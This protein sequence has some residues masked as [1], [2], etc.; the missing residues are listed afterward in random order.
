MI[1]L[2]LG[3]IGLLQQAAFQ[4][5]TT[6][7][8]GDTVGYWQQRVSYTIV[9]TLDE[10]KANLHARGTLVYVNNSPDTLREI[11]VH[12]YLNAF[13]P[14]S[15]WSAVD[16]H[17]N[18]VRFQNLRD[19]DFGYERFTSPPV[20]NG[21][22]VFVDYPGSPDSTVAHFKLAAGLAPHDS[23]R[24]TFEWDA[25][26]STVPRRQGRSGRTYDFAQ[27][28]PKVAVYD[29]GGW[30]P[31][32]LVPAGELYGEYGT[33]DVTMVVRDD[34]VLASSGVPVSGDPGWARVSRNGAP[35]LGSNAYQTVPPAPPVT[36]PDG[37]RAVRFFAENVHHFAWSASPDYRYEG[38]VYVRS[39]PAR[40]HFQTWDT[41]GVH[42]LFKPGDDTTWAGGR[43]VDRTIYALQWLESIWGP[44]AYPQLSNVHR[45]DPGGTEFPM[46]IMDGSASQGLILHEAGH[47]FTYGILGNNEWRSGWMDE[48][49]TSYQTDWAQKL[50][51]QEL[52][53]HAPVPPRLP[54][55]HRANAVVIPPA[56]SAYLAQVRLELLGRAQPIGTSGAEFSEFGIYNDM[57]YDRAELMYGHLRDVMGDTAFRAF[58]H[59]YYNRWAL[60]HVDERAMRM[61]GERTYGHGLTWF[62][63]QWVRG[64]G[65]MDYSLGSVNIRT[66]GARFETTAR[67]TRRGELRHPMP[68]GVQTASGWTF[69][70]ADP[71]VDDQTVSIVTTERP[72]LVELDPNHLT[73]DWDRRNNI[74]SAFLIS[75]R[76]PRVMYNWPYLDQNDR[77]HTIVALSP[78]AWYSEPQGPVFGIR[79][80]TNYLSMVD[81]HDGGIGFS[82]R[83]PRGPTGRQPN[84]L[85]RAQLWA[86]AEN[87]YLPGFDR[88]LMGY[89]GAFNFLDGMLDVS[90]FKKWDLSPFI[91]TP[92]PAINAKL[93][94][95][96]AL[97]TDSLLLPEQW[98]NS[99]LVEAGATG[100][101][102]TAI[103]ADSESTTLRGALA[104]GAT[105]SNRI[106]G[107]ENQ[108]AYLRAEGSIAVVRSI[109][110]TASQVHVRIYG[111]VAHNAPRQRAIFA[112]SEDPLETFN[113]D[114]FRPR[115]ALLK[116]TGINYLPLGGAGF[117]GF[118]YNVPLDG[119]VSGN[120][121]LVQRLFTVRGDWGVASLSFSAFGDGGYG[122]SKLVNLTNSLMSD[123]GTGLIVRGKLYDREMY[124]R[125]DAPVF[126]NQSG[127][128][129]GKGLG[130]NGSVAPRWVITV[131]DLWR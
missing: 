98:S 123:A 104:G 70:R 73:W 3:T 51:P 76:E 35:Y 20:V 40:A 116:Q 103:D 94:V 53:G 85:T 80:K 120:A 43:A 36:V 49:L 4:G 7:P 113:N 64:T 48:G 112:S 95:T 29:R 65:L 60:K 57:I 18:R 9:A 22:P 97:P 100:S 91:H 12:Q 6:P 39:A 10:A 101:Y 52:V 88:P 66:D 44:Y 27:W 77:T 46:M 96:A 90:A 72:T 19:P 110:G 92:G 24:V 21:T 58:M 50:T 61:S 118:G 129:G 99:S 130:G 128:A 42:V 82:S 119:V 117:R 68:V 111:G 55:G 14:D 109:I 28:F 121:E 2:F 115:G 107:S 75:V 126:V 1:S 102:K 67:V 17:E 125:L 71:L 63:D 30:E 86:R 15:K 78:A 31:N 38:G 25:R 124:V 59:D 81:I 33:Y 62:F 8:S 122:S 32:A 34:Q 47:V 106:G 16:D 56:D 105:S 41:V 79:A 89:G 131:G 84:F 87:L 127:L 11:F 37:Y 45:I 13:R 23:I 108:R 83:G 114:L 93:Y 5:A 54:E 69:G 26:P 74:Q